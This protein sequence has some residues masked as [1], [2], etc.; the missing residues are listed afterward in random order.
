[1]KMPPLTNDDTE[2]VL[3]CYRN[4]LATVEAELS[5]REND[6]SGIV[7]ILRE[8]HLDDPVTTEMVLAKYGESARKA[9]GEKKMS[10]L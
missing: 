5:E 3:E 4:R 6:I 9:A 7:A 10:A 2:K 1:M 8:N